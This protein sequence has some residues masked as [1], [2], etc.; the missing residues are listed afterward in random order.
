M[1]LLDTNVI[2]ALIHI[3]PDRSVVAWLDRQPRISIWTT[4]ITVLEIQRGIRALPEG[5]KQSRLSRE[6]DKLVTDRLGGRIASFDQ[7]AAD[8]TATLIV[9]RE[10]RGMNYD[11]EDAMIAGTALARRAVIVTRNTR[12][13]DDLPGKIVNPWL[14]LA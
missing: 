4:A 2:S 9:A 13:F 8:E 3:A 1:I 12:H 5:R 11:L 7:A 6:F 14:D 10:K